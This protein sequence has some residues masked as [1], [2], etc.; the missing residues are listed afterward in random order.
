MG[1]VNTGD[2]MELENG[3]VY[4][5][6]ETSVNDTGLQNIK[7]CI[8]QNELAD[9]M[10]IT[11]VYV[12]NWFKNRGLCGYRHKK[13]HYINSNLVRQFLTH[14]GYSYPNGQIISFQMLKGGSA[15][16]SSAFNLALRLNHYGAKVLV[17]DLDP[18]GNISASFGADFDS[19]VLVDVIENKKRIEDIILKVSDQLDLIPS[20]FD[21]SVLDFYIISK[22]KNLA[23][24]IKN[25][26]EPIRHNYDFVIIDCNPSLSPLNTSI[27]LACDCVFIPVNPD[28]YSKMGLDNMLSEFER[29]NSEYKTDVDY[30]LLFAKFDSQTKVSRE[31]LIHFSS[32]HK[33]HSL[34]S[35]I[36]R[37]NDI[38]ST[39]A[40]GDT[41]F[42]LKNSAAKED[43]DHLARE[44]LGFRFEKE[45]ASEARI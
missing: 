24:F 18:Q 30:K 28:L 17:I 3:A 36:R 5:N 10:G 31:Y 39:T 2:F 7:Y 26:I 23:F 16:T 38:T 9:I 40:S 43:F 42:Q 1:I 37:T 25:L 22:Q 20:N 11:T 14:K 8:Q 12:G 4:K 33:D 45:Q 34:N 44:V 13:Y 32:E 41:I 35:I 15:K 19:P 21:N 29:V 6:S 27:M